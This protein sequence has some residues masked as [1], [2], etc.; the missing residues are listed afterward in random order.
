MAVKVAVVGGGSTY[1]PELVEGF[2]VHGDR[3][4]VD[5]LVLHDV[6]GDRVEI[7]GGLADRM[8]KRAGWTGKLTVTGDLTRAVDGASYVIVQLR[9]GG[10]EAR[11]VDETL[12]LRFG[13]IGQETTGP[14]GFAKA[15]R[16]V[17]VVL[18]IAEAAER[19][20]AEGAWV[21]D[22]T[23]PVGIVTQALLDGGHRAIGLC[24]VAIGF[25]RRF[26]NDFGVDAPEWS[27]STSGSTTFR[28][29]VP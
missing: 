5:E 23:N 9:V 28:G 18:D 15:L 14:G 25:Q 8:L 20:G 10:Q 19:W 27:W 26:A 1:T 11:L 3:L 4:P 17:P 21:V 16:T 24:N 7:V 22:F 13:C 2:V 12:P 6:S 29:S